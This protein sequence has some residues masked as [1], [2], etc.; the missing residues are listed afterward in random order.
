MDS[1][2]AIIFALLALLLLLVQSG[3]LV[4]LIL[5]YNSY[6]NSVKK[7]SLRL[8]KKITINE[9]KKGK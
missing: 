4:V 7:S 6:K 8:T 2:T 5:F 1:G 3:I 9:L